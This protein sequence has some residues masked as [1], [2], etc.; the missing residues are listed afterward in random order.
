MAR[1][2]NRA[3]CARDADRYR[4]CR[5]PTVNL[6]FWRNYVEEIEATP[7]DILLGKAAAPV[8]N[9]LSRSLEKKEMTPEEG[10][11][12]YASEGDDLRSTVQCADIPRAPALC[13]E[14]RSDR[15]RSIN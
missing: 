10:F 4:A 1:P 12:L 9:A 15:H 7:V 3:A 2:G 14:V 5:R 11:L 8:R 6:E 13:H